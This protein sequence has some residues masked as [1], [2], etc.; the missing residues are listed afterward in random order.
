MHQPLMLQI[1]SVGYH[2]S[3]LHNSSS[4]QQACSLVCL[5][6]PLNQHLVCKLQVSTSCQQ[7]QRH[8]FNS[9]SNKLRQLLLI[10]L[11]QHL[12]C[13]QLNSRKLSSQHSRLLPLNMS[14]RI[15]LQT[16]PGL[17]VP[18]SQ[19]QLDQGPRKLQKPSQQVMP[20]TLSLR[21]P[22]WELRAK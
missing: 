17:R 5:W 19:T 1:Y 11:H 7:T 3:Q 14:Q 13:Q 20:C 18:N 10:H 15:K 8:L 9:H 4:L 12:Q 2:P 16:M 6:E 22:T 21:P